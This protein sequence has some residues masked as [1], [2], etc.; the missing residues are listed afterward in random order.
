MPRLETAFTRFKSTNQFRTVV[1]RLMQVG[2]DDRDVHGF[3]S[4]F[5]YRPRCVILTPM[6][7]ILFQ[8]N[9][10]SFSRTTRIR[11]AMW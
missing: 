10:L 6:S 1:Q 8:C 2:T 11:D 9:S 4:T 3:D 7:K 5:R